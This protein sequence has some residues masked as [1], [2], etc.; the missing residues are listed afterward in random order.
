MDFNFWDMSI[1]ENTDIYAFICFPNYS[2]FTGFFLRINSSSRWKARGGL[3]TSS[4]E[5]N[6][7]DTTTNF[8][9]AFTKFHLK[10]LIFIF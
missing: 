10:D 6:M 8:A 7:P 2:I 4:Q 1:D 9:I 5:A 3:R